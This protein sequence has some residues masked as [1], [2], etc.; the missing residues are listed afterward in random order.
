MHQVGSPVSTDAVS[1]WLYGTNLPRRPQ[2][3]AILDTFFPLA[4]PDS[5]EPHPDREAILVA[6]QAGQRPKPARAVPSP[7]PKAS[8]LQAARPFDWPRGNPKPVSGLAELELQTP[9]ADNAGGGHYIQGRLVLGEREDDSGDRSVLLGIQ[10]AFLSVETSEAFV[11][12]GSLIGVR[13]PHDHLKEAPGGVQVVG[14]RIERR[15]ADG[16]TRQILEGE[17]LRGDH[18]VL[19]STTDEAAEASV[20]VT[21]SVPKRGFVVTPIDADGVP[22]AE[23]LDSEAKRA[24]L[25]TLIFEKLPRDD[26]GRAVLQ[27]AKLTRRPQE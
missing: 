5:A 1:H 18:L 20:T 21:L 11:T 7:S 24:I 10:D 26:A 27:R 2:L 25:N 19:A 17:V 13:A 22:V 23:A 14:P 16:S 8:E 4:I 6:W 12:D 3:L 9:K 15:N